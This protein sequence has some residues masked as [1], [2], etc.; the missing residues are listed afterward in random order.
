[1]TVLADFNLSNGG[2]PLASVVQST[3]GNFYGTTNIGGKDEGILFRVAPDGTLTTV[4]NFCSQPKCPDG[5]GPFESPILGND[6]YLYGVVLSGGSDAAYST[7]SGVI[8]KMIPGNYTVLYTFCETTPCVDGAAP[9][10]IVQGVDGNLYG[11]TAVGGEFNEGTFFQLTPA[12]KLTVLHS[13]CALTDCTDGAGSSAPIQ[14]R[15]GNFYGTGGGGTY[16]HGVVYEITPSGT[17][18]VIYNFC[19]AANCTD[20]SQPNA[21]VQDASGNFYGT[22]TE[23]GGGYGTVFKIDSGN[24]FFVL[25]R[26]DQTDAA[27]FAALTIASDGNLYGTSQGPYTGGAAYEITPEGVFTQLYAFADCNV[28]GC[29]PVGSLIQGTNGA[30]YSTA[31]N[32]GSGGYGT[33]FSLANGLS[34]LVETVPVAGKVGQIVI[35]LGNNLIGTSSVTFNGVAAKF[36]VESDTYIKATVPAAA[37]TG[38][39][40]V[41][42]PTGTLSSNPDFRVIK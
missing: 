5:E 10:G 15:D 31:Q 14:A 21:L 29:H 35:V 1:V 25:Y 40:S 34:P 24:H 9:L 32:G 37:S 23:G 41:V 18:N 38:V 6:G 4:Y 11:T 20:G 7:G 28:Q 3:D 33:V 42:T 30:F 2:G 17:Y 39:V 16:G 27:P 22:A 36:T 19:S 12:G 26:F 13:F 8:Y